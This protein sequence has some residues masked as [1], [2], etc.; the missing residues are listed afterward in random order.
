MATF[1][2]IL[3]FAIPTLIILVVVVFIWTKFLAPS[4]WPWLKSTFEGKT[5]SGG[6]TKE[7]VYG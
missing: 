1:D 5:I 4:I 2:A 3:N 7:I 6:R